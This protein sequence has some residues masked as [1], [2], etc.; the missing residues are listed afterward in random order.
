VEGFGTVI[1][2]FI[3]AT[4]ALGDRP[5]VMTVVLG[6]ERGHAAY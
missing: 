6:K 3:V 5:A 1:R 2:S 4:T